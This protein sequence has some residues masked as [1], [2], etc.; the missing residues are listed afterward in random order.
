MGALNKPSRGERFR[1]GLRRL[2]RLRERRAVR[3]MAL[4]LLLFLALSAAV[5]SPRLLSLDRQ[6][7]L[8]VQSLRSDRLDRLAAA[9]TLLGDTVPLIVTGALSAG[10]LWLAGLRPAA[11][12]CLAALLALPLNLVLKAAVGRPRPTSSLVE[13]ILPAV[14][15]SF[16][17]G[18]AMASVMFY[19]FLALL[20][21]LHLVR[22]V[23]RWCVTF[24]L[25]FVAVCISASR[26]YLG[27]H[28]FS[29]VAG[30]WVAGLFFL[31][32]LAELYRKIALSDRAG[33]PADG[34]PVRAGPP[35][36]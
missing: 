16:P 18:H 19:C 26:V 23:A 13:V 25:V 5:H 34:G 8:A 17:S 29:D 2:A 32:L 24:L 6:L 10:L 20:A 30:G 14:G 4:L 1:S 15:L 7:T 27:V 3:A 31:L 21:W 12:M 35:G 22:P 36:H 33:D 11:V 28:W 9:S